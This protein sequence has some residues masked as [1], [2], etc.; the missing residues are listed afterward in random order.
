MKKVKTVAGGSALA[1]FG[2][3]LAGG[4]LSPGQ[5]PQ[6]PAPAPV[7]QFEFMPEVKHDLSPPLRLMKP[8]PPYHGPHVTRTLGRVHPVH[9][10][11]PTNDPVR[12]R[13]VTKALT[14]P[15]TAGLSF[16]G[17][18][19]G[20]Y[21]FSVNVAPP[22][23]EGAV[24]DTQYVQWINLSFAVF[25]K[26]NGALLYGP[27]SGNTLWQGFGGACQNDNNGDPIAQFDKNAH[28]WVMGQFAVSGGPP[29]YE[30]VAVSA[31]ADATGPWYRYQLQSSLFDDYPK[32]AVWPDAY[33]FS[34]NDFNQTF[35]GSAACAFD[36]SAMLAG[37]AASSICFAVNAPLGGFLPSDWDGST[38]PPA[39]SPD[40]YLEWDC[41]SGQSSCTSSTLLNLWR[42][43]VDFA[44]P[45]NS[46]FTG[47]TAIAVASFSAA[48]GG[49]TCIPQPGG[50][51]QQ[52]LDSLADRLMYRL[53]YRRY[54][55][56]ESL[57]TNHAV[58]SP[59]GIRWYEI[60][61]PN[62]TPTV[63][64][65]GTY[66]PDSN[67]RWMGSAAM[68]QSGDLVVGYSLSNS[69]PLGCPPGPDCV[70]PS[71]AYAGRLPADTPGTLEA[72]T[73]VL[74]G[75][76]SQTASL[77]RWGDYSAMTIDPAND[78]TFWYTNMYLKANGTFN[79]STWVNSFTFNSCSGYQ[80]SAG[81]AGS[82]NAG[83]SVHVPVTLTPVNGFS[84]TVSLSATGLPAGATANFNPP[85]VSASGSSTLTISTTRATPV[86]AY[87]VWVTGTSSINSESA[88]TSLQVNGTPQ[89]TLSP[90][91]LA[92]RIQPVGTPANPISILLTNGGTAALTINGIA[93]GGDFRETNTCGS[94]IGPGASCQINVTFTPSAGGP[95]KALLSVTDNAGV[96]TAL[97]TGVGTAV[98]LAPSTLSFPN[99]SVGS[100]S[101]AETITVKNQG[102]AMVHLWQIAI[103]G[104]NSDDYLLNNNCASTLA[105]GAQCTVGVSFKPA[106]AGARTA[107]L[108]FSDDG[109]GSPQAVTLAGNALLLPL[110]ASANQRYL[111]DQNGTP[112]LIMGDAPQSMV[113]NLNTADM[114]TYLADR[115]R[116]GFNALWVNLLCASYT[117]CNSDGTT[118]DGVAPFT[119][120]SSPS[121]Y[122]LSKPNSTYFARVDSMLNLAATYNQV[123][124]LDPIETGGWLVTLENNG[125]TKAYNYGVYIGDRYKNFANIV[126]LH[127]ND[128]QSWSSSSTD[129]NLVKQVMA[130]IASVDSNHL[131][132]IELNYNSSY[133]NQD[134]ALG[135]LLTLDSAYTY[136]ETY[137]IVLQSYNS[138][139][140]VPTYLVEANYEYENNTGAL[141]GAAGPYVLR[142]E[143]YWTLLSGGAGQLYGSHYTWTFTSGWQSFLDSPGALEIRYLNQLF[144]SVAWWNLVPD[145]THQVVTAGYGTYNGSNSNLTTAT[146]CVTGWITNGSLALTYCPNP[147]T[148]TV[149]LALFSGPVTAQ[150]YDPS[151]GTST[152]ILGSPFANSGNHNF[153]TPGNNHDGDPDWVLEL[154]AGAG[155]ARRAR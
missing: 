124:F 57:V 72:E 27:A 34:F 122:D 111:V 153:T 99:Q 95:R 118:Y 151:N 12:Q 44:T 79:W 47:P 45:T 125:G 52:K 32:I 130:G 10:Y 50:A 113:G 5:A 101:A 43:H 77:N 33:Y 146:Y 51:N 24:G 41:P 123:V 15:A 80:V 53:A 35:V 120:G 23:T 1:L 137:D 58:G 87:T 155:A 8:I 55:D 129:N 11:E 49:G 54:A 108:L 71:I 148:L 139:P 63:Y 97:L 138:A 19:Y 144:G 98:S 31:T 68:D 29:Y 13:A 121:N 154:T 91:S 36:R 20:D 135:S 110:K 65:Q 67:W 100:T 64:Q 94:G 128:F 126:W 149:N 37:Q 3:L 17:L 141:P 103:G 152:A 2:L 105:S 96:Q 14:Q 93:A 83:Q 140:T 145:Q 9:P 109:G 104:T 150:W 28:R 16:A 18:G 81:S 86:G 7:R 136:Y 66:A 30:C 119:S 89:A 106:A 48:C 92:F 132:T 22:D 75:K 73:S 61:D 142:E 38:P 127:G 39:G 90:Q 21:G 114:N 69:A 117:A 70:Y 62:G 84:G 116:L 26:G 60:R 4:R 88:S 56:H 42:F 78:C 46:S 112:F 133:S 74:A 147:S 102:A 6:S 143:A 107:S 115:E 25:N 76:G 131:Q 134:S 85:S 82:V 59:A 40:F